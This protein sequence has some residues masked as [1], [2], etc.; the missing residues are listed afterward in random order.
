MTSIVSNM[1]PLFFGSVLGIGGLAN[2]WRVATRLWGAPAAIGETLAIIAFALWLIW[3]GLYAAKWLLHTAAAREDLRHPVQ[4]LL[5][6]LVPVTTLIAS[7]AI[8]PHLPAL[9]WFIFVL[10]A[11][12]VV[13]YAAWSIG[14][15][16]QGGRDVLHTTA[17]LYMPTVGGGFVAALAC[18]WFGH[19]TAG[20]MFFGFGLLSW[21]SMESVLLTRLFTNRLP[22]EMRSTMG[23]HLAPP[24]V[25][26]V[27]YMSLEPGPADHAALMLF[28]YGCFL[29]LVMIRLVPWLR[30]QTFGP[31][32]WAYTFGISALPLAALR[33]VEKGAGEPV[34]WMAVPM[35]IA[36]NL[37]I[38]W[39]ALRS[40]VL[41]A[42]VLRA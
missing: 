24:A 1:R 21:M 40:L 30:E 9:S 39:I 29:A 13:L 17:I 38:G 15:L 33:L 16:W 12:G 6:A 7:L 31:G 27:A 20:W 4:A 28:G 18:G 36:A 22:V 10:G 5:A 32:A 25:A 11:S 34:T 3:C 37:I 35:F 2:G 42:R 23:V 26:C 8:G 19:F 41:I 14:G